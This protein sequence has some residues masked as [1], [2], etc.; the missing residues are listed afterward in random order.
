MLLYKSYLISD[1]FFSHQRDRILRSES[2][3]SNISGEALST[4][5]FW[6]SSAVVNTRVTPLPSHVINVSNVLFGTHL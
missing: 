1:C 4:E 6:T 3:A 2:K 5:T